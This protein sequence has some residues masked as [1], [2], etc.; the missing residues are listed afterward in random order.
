[1]SD[2]HS[3]AQGNVYVVR[4]GETAW[5]LTGQHTGLTDLAL[6][7][8][9][10]EQARALAEWLHSM[11]FTH[12][13]SSPLQRALRTCAL[14]GFGDRAVLDADLVEWNYGD[15]EGRTLA[16]IRGLDPGWELFRDGCPG[17]ES[18]ADITGRADRI[19]ARLAALEGNV[20]V[21]SSGHVLRVL[22]A[23]WLEAHTA[24]GRNL[25]LDPAGVSVLGYDHDGADR[26]IRGWN[27]RGPPPTSE[28][29]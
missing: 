14:A 27:H 1:M 18:V 13:L 24:L 9:G 17:G 29:A 8:R 15:Y 4:H 7:R 19:V 3:P 6:T 23:R 11:S 22:A 16:Q 21:F 2:L 26:V 12:V 20:I 28:H 10:E 25:V 5:S